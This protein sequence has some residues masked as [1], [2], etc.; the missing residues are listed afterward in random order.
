MPIN[1]SISGA[2]STNIRFTTN[3]T[4]IVLK[5]EPVLITNFG[6]VTINAIS[7]N[8]TV[9]TNGQVLTS[10][11]S[12]IYWGNNSGGGISFTTGNGLSLTSNV[13]FVVAN[14]GI[15]ANSSGTFVDPTYIAT[16]TSNNTN[17]LGGVTLN[18][19]QSSITSNAVTAYTNAVSDAISNVAPL[20][21]SNAATAYTNAIAY[22]A[23]NA[24]VNSTF[25]T[26]AGLSANVATLTSNNT[27]FVGTVSA[28]NVVSN[29]QLQANLANYTPNTTVYSTFAQNTAIYAY[30]ASNIAV[31]STFA[32]NT[33][34]YA[35]AASNAYVNSTFQTTVGLASNVA[36][37]T[38][39]NSTNFGGLSLATVQSQITSNAATAYSNAVANAAASAAALYQTTA[40]LSA[41]VLTLT[42]NNS[43]NFGGLSLATVQSQITGNAA[44]AYSNAVANAAASA[45]ALYQ[46]TAGLSANVATLTSNNS[47]NF[48]GLS[49]ATVQSQITSNAATA[50][51]NAIAIAASDASSKA[52]TAYANAV[53]N[54]AALY[55]T[56]AGLSANVATLTSNNTTNFGGLSLATIQSQITGNAATAYSN[57]VANAAAS[58]AA[59]YQTTAGLASNVATLTSNNTSFV[60]TVSAAN[61][62]SNV[63]LQSNLSGY[64]T[65]SGLNANIAA[66]LPTYT[67]IVAGSNLSISGGATVSGNLTVTGNLTL[68]GS[69]TFIN[70]TVITTNDLNII[71]ANSASTNALANNSGLVI[72]T[73]ANLVYNSS[74]PA[75]Q[76]NV[77]FVPYSN[78]INLGYANAAWNIYAT[79]ISSNTIFGRTIN[80]STYVATSNLALTS[81]ANLT[82]ASGAAIIDTTGSQGTV[83]QVLTSNGAGNVYWSTVSVNTAAQYTF[84]NT[85]TFT[86]VINGTANVA[87]YIGT[88]SAANV[89]SN[90]QLQANLANYTTNTTVYSTFAQNTA[91]YA[92]AASNAYVNSTFQTIAGLASNVA[93]LTS[94]NT[95]FVGTVSAA[96]VVSNVQLQANLANYTPNT[97]VYST[98]AQNTAI[99][100]YAAS[101]IAVYST[102]AQNTAIYA[103]AASNAYVNSTFQTMAGLSANV[104]TLT[105]N[106][107]TYVN[108]KTEGNL[109]VNSAAT[110]T[111]ANNTT[112]L[113]GQLA[114]YYTNATN[115][116]TGTLPWAQAPSGTV[117]TSG[118]FTFS[119]VETFNANVVIAGNSTSQLLISTINA[120]SNGVTLTNNLMQIGNTSVYTNVIPGSV[121]TTNLYGTL[122]TASQPNIT[123]NNSNYLGGTA[124][125][126]YQT[127]A[128]LAA[129]V[130]T[131]TSNNTSFVGTVSAANVVS[132]VQ[133][134][135]NLLNYT[136]N[137]TVYSTFAQNTA[138]YA[139]AASNAYVNSTFQTMA[140]LSANVATLTSNAALYIGNS[141]GTFANIVS[142][143]S[144]NAATSYSNG[145]AYSDSKAATAYTNAV[146]YVANGVTNGAIIAANATLFAGQAPSYYTNATN[147]NTGTLPYTQLPAN[148]VISSNNTTFTGTTTHNANLTVSG[149]NSASVFQVGNSSGNVIMWYDVANG[150]IAQFGGSVNNFLQI[151]HTNLNTG[152]NA[153]TDFS[154]YDTNGITGYNFIDIGIA[155]NAY[156][157]AAWTILNPSDGYVYT[158][159]SNFAIGVVG[160]NN[161]NFFAGGSLAANKVMTL[162]S[163]ALALSN[164]IGLVANGSNGTSGQV[165]TSNGTGLFWSTPS[166]GTV[167]GAGLQD[168]FMLM[169][170]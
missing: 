106:N 67:G 41:N 136:T 120:T 123:A 111:N 94:N 48:G 141:S 30:A 26:M 153:S 27:S 105:S 133:L 152:N 51:S 140:G 149:A 102:F 23:S 4:P 167:S 63:Q 28:A 126:G 90:T 46:T 103:Y 166:G 57:A 53:A 14:S 88:L 47:T 109:N 164:S 2:T 151:T 89:V 101:N 45:A 138:I 69:T 9:G 42:S 114:S 159:N 127:T 93:T 129:N 31:Y 128:G 148:V 73:S 3:T 162:N 92:Y 81:T 16:L 142:M 50:Y 80:A 108:G 40:G 115:I 29:V 130:A 75:W 97:T 38:S 91:I 87:N 32:Q 22:A 58:A 137:T 7:A 11:G 64:Q 35:Y 169:G 78:N 134:Q 150:S 39:N 113:N 55:Q 17:Y 70:A 143:I 118:T 68:A 37:L 56:T 1:V 13:L 52:A 33:A 8:G 61:V 83:G 66:Y 25:Q 74:Y 170:A 19:I 82:I 112:Y 155:G 18:A 131:L 85:I 59:L 71:L 158:A 65:I 54:A 119:G 125:S 168:I 121:Y 84:S 160:S 79:A 72:G 24:Y 165:L 157:N 110:A 6:T 124:A 116:T 122:Q 43:T 49:L 86:Q 139:Y 95:S 5:N 146:N 77:A 154:L 96:N 145:T 36:T 156:A 21:T 60:G 76:S 20:I 163:S 147:I 12:T 104:A 44:T 132:N 100:A 135:A 117:N 161:I 99:Y 62:V 15:I 107:T 10:N 144:G 98:F 34:I